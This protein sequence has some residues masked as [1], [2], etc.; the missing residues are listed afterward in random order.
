MRCMLPVK[1]TAP[2]LT[3]VPVPV[4]AP[5]LVPVLMWPWSAF[6]GV[7]R[8]FEAFW[9]VTHTAKRI[10]TRQRKRF[11]VLSSTH[12]GKHGRQC[13]YI[14]T[15]H[16][17]RHAVPCC[18]MICHTIVPCYAIPYH[19][20]RGANSYHSITKPRTWY[21]ILSWRRCSSLA[22]FLV[23]FFLLSDFPVFFLRPYSVFLWSS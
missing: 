16:H 11:T 23:R 3:P 18:T 12:G 10:L 8:W 5:V 13:I 19:M 2:G 14:T 20:K 22:A 7:A 1:M 21:N 4:L 17:T 15:L 9:G 6:R